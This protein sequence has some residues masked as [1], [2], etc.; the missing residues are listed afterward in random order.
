MA[1]QRFM[2]GTDDKVA[3]AFDGWR[4]TV[5]IAGDAPREKL[6][7]LVGWADAHSPVGC[8]VRDPAACSLQVEV[9]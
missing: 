2:L 4:T 7:E 6:Q 1:D 8:Q 5:K 3:G 9:L